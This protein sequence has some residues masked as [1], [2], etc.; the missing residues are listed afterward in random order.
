M[1]LRA[2]HERYGAVAIKVRRADSKR[3]SL[4]MECELMRL[5]SP[6]AP[7]P[8]YCSKD[9]IVMEYVDG[10]TLNRYVEMIR[11]CREAVTLVLK[12]IAVA[13]WL[14]VIGISHKELSTPERHVIVTPNG[15][16]KV[17]DYETAYRGFKCNVCKV[18]SW[19]ILRKGLLRRFCNYAGGEG[20]VSYVRRYKDGDVEGYTDLLNTLTKLLR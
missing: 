7:K 14:D 1:V 16:V 15:R 11:S 19:L 8:L 9:F 13:R 4:V 18:V 12:V 2:E 20:I 17:V 10:H 6:V 5:A 3:D